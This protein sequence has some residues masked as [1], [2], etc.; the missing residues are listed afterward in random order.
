VGIVAD[1]RH[2]TLRTRPIGHVYF[3]FA[4]LPPENHTNRVRSRLHMSF[5]IRTKVD[6]DSIG[7]LLRQAVS[8]VDQD[9]PVFA[10]QQMDT[11]LA[12]S[13]R[14]TRFLTY[15]LGALAVVAVLLSAIGLYGVMNYAVSR[16][17]QEI[18]I[19]MAL[20]A[21]PGDMAR[22]VLCQAL[23]IGLAGLAAGLALALALTRFLSSI[24]YG[25]TPADPLTL[26]AVC[27]LLGVVVLAA[28]YIPAKRAS[29]MDPVVALR[30][31]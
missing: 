24:L 17:T 3:P 19:R 30:N 4:Q 8:R 7:P 22:M 26:A 2:S 29:R 9:V 10:L 18:G 20:G 21:E 31:D 27:L 15:L 13:A 1:I 16:R 23:W 6:A 14:E 28:G 12:A 11:Y 25:I 5:A